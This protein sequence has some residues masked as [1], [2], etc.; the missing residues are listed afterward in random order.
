MPLPSAT[1]AKKFSKFAGSIRLPI[2]PRKTPFGPL[3]L[4]AR[5]VV[6]PPVKR[7]RTGSVTA[8][9]DCGFDLKTLK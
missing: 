5:T 7:L 8:V 4:W 1:D 9:V 3:S 2:T 6:Q